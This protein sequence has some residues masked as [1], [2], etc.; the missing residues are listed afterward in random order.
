VPAPARADAPRDKGWWTATNPGGL[1]TD[2]PAPPDVPAS[3]LLI[4]GGGGGA[5]T[6]YAAVLYE[7]DPSATASTLTLTIAPNSVTTPLATLQVCPLLQ[8]INHPDQ[9]GPLSDAPPYNCAHKVTAAPGS[10]GKGYQ[11]SASALV[12]DRVVAVAILP[13]GP[14][15]RVV[16]NAPDANSLATQAGTSDTGASVSDAGATAASPDSAAAPLGDATSGFASGGGS[17][18]PNLS[19]SLPGAA[20]SGPA[21]VSPPLAGASPAASAG[22]FVP[23]VSSAPEKATPLLVVLFVAAALGGG[24]LWLYAGRQPGSSVVI[25]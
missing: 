23:A 4:Q 13:T 9:G 17:G 3:G 7:L 20:V 15:D 14:V 10:D 16:L 8:P 1:P 19:D 6:A 11:F 25:G 21:G 5:P 12:T 22:S 24:A 18:S 2:P